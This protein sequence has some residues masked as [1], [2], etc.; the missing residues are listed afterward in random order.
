MIDSQNER[1]FTTIG[2]EGHFSEVL[3]K[4]MVICY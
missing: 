4:L 3:A 2:F 1:K